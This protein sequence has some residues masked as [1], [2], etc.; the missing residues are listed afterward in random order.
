MGGVVRGGWEGWYPPELHEDVQKVVPRVELGQSR[1]MQ[2]VRVSA[3]Q[4]Q[5]PACDN[6]PQQTRTATHTAPGVTMAV[7]DTVAATHVYLFASGVSS[8]TFTEPRGTFNFSRM[9]DSIFSLLLNS[10]AR[11]LVDTRTSER[12]ECTLDART[13]LERPIILIVLVLPP[14]LP[15]TVFDAHAQ[16][17]PMVPAAFF[18]G[19]RIFTACLPT[20]SSKYL[21][22]RAGARRQGGEQTAAGVRA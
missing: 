14:A 4:R 10:P 17:R 1:L 11:P 6:R 12:S 7:H 3:C 20:L 22:R 19:L 13:L 16:D 21:C 9:R 18:T 15:P 5:R 2:H 8:N